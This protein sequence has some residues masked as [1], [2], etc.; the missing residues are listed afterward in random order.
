MA[1]READFKEWEAHWQRVE[2]FAAA[3]SRYAA[4]N[5]NAAGL[6]DQG[7]DLVQGYFRELK[8]ALQRRGV[9][10]ATIGP[11]EEDLRRLMGLT[12]GRNS[13]TSYRNSVRD[14][15]SRRREI[16]TG[17]EF[18]I[19]AESPSTAAPPAAIEAAILETLEGM[20]PSAGASYKQV[21]LDLQHKGR[22]S[23]RGTAAELREVLREV[24]DTLAPDDAVA[25]GPGFKLEPQRKGPTMA[26]KVRFILRARDAPEPARETAEN[27]A[28]IVD[29]SIATLG[30]SV[31]TR[32]A[33]SVHTARTLQEVR[34]FKMYADA[35]L[36]EL[37][38]IHKPVLAAGTA[39]SGTS[40]EVAQAHSDK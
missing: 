22:V 35:V 26:Q 25:A 2:S 19:G 34:N 23:N 30:R 31:Y 7:R 13:K 11:L 39:A 15:R 37:L 9:T 17:L 14:I 3:L 33:M 1:E 32:G 24:L 6:R 36:G 8:P 28:A 10:D 29:Q 21:L 27:A 20:I 12:S 5:V 38:E 4:Q 16:E 18:L 40:Q